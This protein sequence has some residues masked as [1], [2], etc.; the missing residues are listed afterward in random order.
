MLLFLVF[1]LF[2]QKPIIKF[3]KF[4][5]EDGMSQSSIISSIQDNR[6]FM[7][8]ATL[9]GLN[10]YDGYNFKVYRNSKIKKNTIPDNIV[11]VLYET[12]DNENPTLWLGTRAGGICRYNKL[13]DNFE[14]FSYSQHKKN[15]VSSNEIND[16]IGDNKVLWI[17]TNK[18][19]NKF[20]QKVNKFTS[21]LYSDK[22]NSISSDTVL[23]LDFDNS[24]NL[25]IGTKRGINFFNAKNNK[26]KNFKHLKIFNTKINDI[27]FENNIVWIATPIGLYSY[28]IKN[29]KLTE[30]KISLFSK[31]DS[32][33]NASITTFVKDKNDILW[34]GSETEGLISF[35][36]KTNKYFIYKHE[37]V[38]NQ[39]LSTNSILS[40]YKDVSGIL[41]VGTSLG[42]VNKWN[43][44]AEDIDVFRH[45][46]Y[47]ENS[48]S[49]SQVRSFYVDKD[50]NIWVGTV[51]GGLNRWDKETN[52]FFH[53]KNN[54]NN[55]NSISNNHIRSMLEDNKNRFW[56]ATDGGGLNLFD[57]K[58]EKFI[59]YKNSK[60]T[61]SI[62]CNRVWKIIEDNKNRLWVGTFGGGLN[63]LNPEKE[64]FKHYKHSEKNKNSISSDLVTSILQDTKG[65]IWIGTFQGLNKFNP[66][67]ESFKSYV[68]E[69]N[70]YKSIS[71]NRVY[72]IFEDSEGN[73]WIG[74]KGGL[75]KFDLEKEEFTVFT[76]EN[77]DLP[78]DVILGITEENEYIWLSTNNGISRMHKKTGE[79]K[80][81]DIGDGLQSNEFL[82]GSCYKKKDGEILFGGIDGFNAFYPNEITDNPHKPPVLITGFQISNQYIDTDTIISSKKQ[83]VLEHF[84]NDISF[85]FVALDFIFPQKN[86]YKYILIGNDKEWNNAGFRRF[87]K[88]TNLKPGKYIFKVI[89][90]NN[91]D[92]WNE[93]GASLNIIIKPALWQTLW[94]KIL[95]IT[96]IVSSII[97]FFKMR[98]RTI[99]KRNEELETEVRKRT[100]EIRQQ[101]EEIKSQRD[102][103]A[104]QKDF[105]TA[106]KQEITDSILYAKK[107][108]TAALPTN[109]YITK[110]LPEH[111]ILF[112]PRDIVSGDFYWIGRKDSKIIITAVDCTGH[113]V[114]G[115]FMSM[116]GI[117]FL[118]KIVNEKSI[119][120][121]GE[122]LDK[123]R[124]NIINALHPKGYETESKD[125]MDMSLCVINTK[126]N[127]IEFSGAYNS[128]FYMK[129]E[130]ITEIKADRMPVALYDVMK[131][132]TVQT[133]NF[134]KGDSIYMF[135]D[136]YPDQFGGPENKKFMKRKLKSLLEEISKKN[137]KEQHQILDTTIEDWKGNEP[138]IDDILIIGVRL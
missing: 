134:N 1:T 89:G 62:S 138:Q 100:F 75:N 27:N 60:D 31:D 98:M 40:I 119:T 48:L 58:N 123:L 126:N 125:G 93:D 8:F 15:S 114:P 56:I 115:A 47:N 108:Q 82:A 137:M 37:P 6:G 12:K 22:N 80:N 130:K 28:D 102:E 26:F 87:A 66:E 88:Y 85:D 117:S 46:P 44:A 33:I 3:E 122:I 24:G 42:G 36:I 96:F 133:F 59:S 116:L 30:Y 7:W 23:C 21:F 38:N 53:Y 91:D 29:D 81:F 14:T 41:W 10:L 50:E 129:N 95:L 97:L 135:S 54:P 120:N 78:N 18:G 128:L 64:T 2:A 11:T 43:R 86:K 55:K 77:S 69:E 25:W 32:K 84:Q 92:V 118:N 106:Q 132:F 103:L 76:T 131:P 9:D 72:T 136:G 17:A 113:G 61:N 94:F 90:S 39:S 127:T 99:K 124:E 16:I 65:N 71:N 79:I 101:N 110:N 67:E 45:N 70:N 74:T 34:L 35:N 107:I 19:L 4:S 111:F 49:A 121:P 52:K 105:I 73:L 20:N 51:E 83:I 13:K 104:I 109:D 5:V 112:K 63:L 68:N 57:T